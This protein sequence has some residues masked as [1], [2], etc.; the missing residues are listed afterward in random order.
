MP[1]FPNSTHIAQEI[2]GKRTRL[3]VSPNRPLPKSRRLCSWRPGVC[4][5]AWA[6]AQ[7]HWRSLVE[8]GLEEGSVVDWVA[9]VAR[10]RE[11]SIPWYSI[12]M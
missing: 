7:R 12:H 5:C 10:A 4:M 9:C 8:V 3:G 6:T 1:F 11:R 2:Q